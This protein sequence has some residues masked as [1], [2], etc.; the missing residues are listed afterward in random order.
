M[1]VRKRS[2]RVPLHYQPAGSALCGAACSKMLLEYH[3]RNYSL[4]RLAREMRI[5]TGVWLPRLGLWFIGHGFDVSIVGWWNMFPKRF[6]DLDGDS[7][8]KELLRWC[9]R[10]V[11]QADADRRAHQ[12]L[13]PPFLRA[14]GTFMPRPVTR[15]DLRAALRRGQP[16]LLVVDAAILYR[17]LERSEPHLVVV[18]GLEGDKVHLNDPYPGYG[19]SRVYDLDAILHACYACDSTA[20]FI[21]PK[22]R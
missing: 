2:S 5:K 16:P 22:G 10:R 17:T 8:R 7:R 6:I 19:G 1:A 9:R 20:V 21:R 3:G 12:R 14:G 11:T 13:L 15:Q 18:T 4:N